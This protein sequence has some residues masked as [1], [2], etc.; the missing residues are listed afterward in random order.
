MAVGE[1]RPISRY[2]K[3][4]KPGSF[5]IKDDVGFSLGVLTSAGDLPTCSATN[6]GLEYRIQP[7]GASTDYKAVCRWNGTAYEWHTSEGGEDVAIGPTGPTG[8]TGT[9]GGTGNTGGTGPTGPTGADSTVT[10][11]TGP[12][13]QRGSAGP[14]GT[15]GSAGDTGPTGPTG[16]AGAKGDQGTQGDTG[17]TG[18]TGPTGATGPAGEHGDAG[19]AGTAGDTGPTGPTG[20]AG[21]AGAQGDRGAQGDTGATGAT[22]PTGP[23]GVQGVG[24]DAGDTGPT[25]AAGVGIQ[26]DAGATG[27]TGPAGAGSSYTDEDARDAI[28]T[29]LVAG[30]NID[31]TVSDGSDTITIDVESL[32]SADITDFAEVVA[33][34]AGAMFSSNTET[35]ITATYQDADNT[36]DLVVPVL[37]E[38]DMSSDSAAHLATQQSIKAYV[39][40]EVAGI[41]GISDGDKGDITVSGSGTTWTIDADAVTYAKIQDVSA[42]DRLLGRVSASAGVIEE[43]VFTDFAQSILDDADEA[44]FKATTNLEIGVDVQA[45]D[46]DL[47]TLATAFTT[48]SASGAA[49]LAFHED[50]DNGTNR[51]LL[52]GA[53]STADVTVTLPA[54]T[55]TVA[56]TSD[57]PSQA[58]IEEYARDALGT[59][60]TAGNNIDITVDDGL[61]T[62]TIAVETL[63]LADI[64]DV[65]ASAAELNVLDGIPVGLTATELGY[66]DGVT[67]AIQTQLDGKQ[68]LDADLTDIA[69][70]A[71]AQGDVIVRGAAGWERLAAGTAGH[72]LQ[73]QGSG[74]TPFWSS[75]GTVP[76]TPEVLP[77]TVLARWF[78][79]SQNDVLTDNTEV[80]YWVD[81]SPNATDINAFGH[82][83]AAKPTIQTNE[84]NGLPAMLFSGSQ[85]F[86]TEGAAGVTGDQFAV[87]FVEKRS[88]AQAMDDYWTSKD[89]NDSAFSVHT[90]IDPTGVG[91]DEMATFQPPGGGGVYDSIVYADQIDLQWHIHV[92]GFNRAASYGSLDG[93]METLFFGDDDGD[94][95]GA[96]IDQ[97]ITIGWDEGVGGSPVTANA[98][99]GLMAEFALING[100]LSVADA[101]I[102]EGYL[103]HKYNIA[104]DPGH[105]YEFTPPLTSEMAFAHLTNV[106][107]IVEDI[108]ALTD[109]GADRILFW[110]DSDGNI[111]WLTPS[112]GITVSGTNLTSS[113]TG[114]GVINVTI[115]DG[116]NEIADGI[117]CDIHIPNMALTI[118]RASILATAFTAGSTGSIVIDLWK[119]TYANFPPTDADSVTAAAPPTI[120]TAAKSEDATLTSWD[121]TW[122]ARDIVRVNIDSCTTIALCTL[123]LH[124]T[125]TVS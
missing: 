7:G 45:Y 24:G 52:Q 48:A 51:V 35:F 72:F 79:A 70:I 58:T 120:T 29:A 14:A 95:T 102:W 21:G 33:D 84:V 97:G 27:P 34:T 113:H 19:P 82:S 22:G 42:S 103:A 106:P 54:T 8:P 83:A 32:T 38:D 63:T 50:T 101:Q 85:F 43:V 81:S 122:D 100:P 74:E 9:T 65:T 109:P 5:S 89:P 114:Q 73:T 4:R 121:T 124:F 57:I 30:N 23:Q 125:Y 25:G 36:I 69:A 123:S 108:A 18:V 66:V 11:P 107:P 67:S 37:D 117:W 20:A 31:I 44:T 68:P 86:D 90:G 98:F 110:D 6:Q 93:S 39:D 80:D 17:A 10:G 94:L 99:N 26:G 115:G 59:A 112:T 105:P 61:D 75:A 41:G 91:F 76:W 87:I 111:G 56:L 104:L 71:D 47:T 3:H 16:S 64:S 60:L 78:D 2:L 118:T 49:S 92:Q 88:V 53:A 116:T 55:G 46:A 62:I 12:T 77:G 28:G 40:A 15:Q 1:P 13:G 96:S 119:D